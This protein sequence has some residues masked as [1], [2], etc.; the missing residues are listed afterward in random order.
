MPALIDGLRL[1]PQN[2]RKDEFSKF[3]FFECNTCG[4]VCEMPIEQYRSYSSDVTETATYLCVLCTDHGVNLTIKSKKAPDGYVKLDLHEI[5]ALQD[6]GISL[7]KISVR[8]GKE[9]SISNTTVYNKLSQL[10]KKGVLKKDNVASKEDNNQDNTQHS[11]T[12]TQHNVD[13]TQHNDHI[14]DVSNMVENPPHYTAGGIETI[15][16]IFAAV[17]GLPAKMAVCVGNIIKYVWR[18]SRKNGLE[19]LYKARWY[20]DKLISILESKQ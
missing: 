3:E 14:S 8:Y 18:F 15:D 7:Y 19:D 12:D 20:L 2:T 10:V 4:R 11:E 1:S 9:Y 13:D 16:A 17:E 6:Q 5:R